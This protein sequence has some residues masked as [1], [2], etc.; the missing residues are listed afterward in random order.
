M[1]RQTRIL[2]CNTPAATKTAV[3]RA[4]EVIRRGGLVAF[5]TE[6]VY[7]LGANALDARAVRAVFVAKGRPSDNPL[8]VHVASADQARSL[9]KHF[10]PV[11]E[12]LARA[13]MPGALTLVLRHNDTLPQIVTANLDTV[14]VRIPNHNVALA[15]IRAAGVPLVAPSANLSG[16]PS[17]TTAQHVAEDLRGRV[18]IILDGGPTRI[19]LESTVVDVTCRPPVILRLGGVTVEQI[20]KVIGRVRTVATAAQSARSPGTRHKHYSPRARVKL[21]PRGN[22]TMFAR[23]LENATKRGESVAAIIHSRALRNVAKQFRKSLVVRLLPTQAE[24]FARELFRAIR[25]LDNQKPDAIIVEK[26]KPTGLGAAILD[27]LK[28]AAASEKL[29][30]TKGS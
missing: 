3:A 1:P 5:P 21:V 6:T 22:A 11:A 9:A 18:D 7:G 26:V 20:R 8:I 16:H 27:R 24:K 25:E 2:K 23:L 19:G 29:L 30:S 4:V 14:A 12:K 17:P 13:F 10:P 28:R 15:L